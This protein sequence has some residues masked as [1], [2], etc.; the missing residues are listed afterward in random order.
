MPKF[1]TEGYDDR[2]CH[3]YRCFYAERM[4]GFK[5]VKDWSNA[6]A[7]KLK[8]KKSKEKRGKLLNYNKQTEEVQAGMMEARTKEWKKW[9]DF[10]AGI[11]IQG[12]E[13][14]DILSE[15][16]QEIPTQWVETDK[17]E[18]LKREDDPTYVHVS[19]YKARLVARGDLEKGTENIRSDSPTC[20][21]EAQ[22]LIFSFAA[23]NRI[24][25]K[26]V[27]ISNAYFQGEQ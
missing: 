1:G 4:E 25:I 2:W 18:F 12:K 26:S 8:Q 24:K 17:N 6:K 5:P 21:V 22:N 19:K 13:L 20:D 15:G 11:L 9:E 10:N 3:H 16:F 14:N 27:D 23:S 7:S